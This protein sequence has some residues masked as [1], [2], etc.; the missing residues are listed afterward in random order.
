MECLGESNTMTSDL[1]YLTDYRPE[2]AGSPEKFF[3][4]LDKIKDPENQE[5]AVRWGVINLF[6]A[7]KHD[8]VVPLVN[9]LGKRTFKSKRLKDVAIQTAFYEGAQ[10]G[11]QD[12]VELYCEHPAITSEEYADGLYGSWN[13]GKPNQVFPFL[14]EQADQGDLD[15]AKKKYAHEDYE[16]FRQAI[17]EALKTA[18]PA[19]SRHLR[20]VEKVLF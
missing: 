4:I 3:R 16:K 17:D 15:K 2:L 9:A 7:G 1:C 12:I 20:L 13:D 14:L 6:K 11:N 10:R 19:G 8:L 18:P 5:R